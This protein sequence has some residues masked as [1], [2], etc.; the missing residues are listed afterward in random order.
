MA[1]RKDIEITEGDAAADPI[2]PPA[3]KSVKSEL[4]AVKSPP[5]SP[6]S[7]IAATS[8]AA[9]EPIVA[10]APAT[11]S[12]SRRQRPKP[13]RRRQG[14]A[15]RFAMR[16]RH[17][18][19]GVLAASVTFAA[20]LGAVI[21]A[22]A[23]GGISAPAHT[24]RRRR[25]AEQGDAAIDRQA[26]QGD[27][28]A[29]NQP[30]SGEQVGAHADRQDFRSARTSG[31]RDHRLDRG[32]ADNSCRADGRR[33]RCRARRSAWRV[34]SQAPAASRWCRA[35]PSTISATATSLWKAT[36]RSIKSNSARRC[37]AS[38]RYNRSSG[39]TAAGWC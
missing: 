13:P 12:R 3:P 27:R 38:A 2:G 1:K 17:K 31:R 26:Q 10:E 6:A 18:R 11:E 28:H 25:R 33:C 39:K 24:R 20:A 22:L 19:Y 21:G 15:P 9:A 5:L 37:P 14:Y 4:P 34:E 32:A 23:S 8:P 29:E 36:A 7:E 16:P 30:R 35:G